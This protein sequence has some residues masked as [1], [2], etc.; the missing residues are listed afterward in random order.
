M[1]FKIKEKPEDF[2]VKEIIDIPLGDSGEYAYYKLRKVDRN[3][4]DIVR[5]LA[6]RF[7]LPVKNITFAGLKD[8]NAVTEQYLAIKGL[9]KIPKEVEGKNYKLSL[10]GFSDQPLELGNFKGNYFEIVVRNVSKGE[11]I[12]AERNLEF[13]QKYGF[14]NYFGEQRF[15][16]VK[17]A[18][19]FI[20]K[21]LLAH[22][23]EEALREYLLS[24]SD[25]RM[26]RRLK[27]LWG[28]WKEYLKAM[29][30]QAIYER[31]IVEELAKGVSYKQSFLALPKNIRLMFAFTYQSYLWNR[32]LYRFI[33]RYFSFCE[34]P[35]GI[36]DWTYAF[37]THMN[38]TIFEKVKNLE[39]PYL[40][41]EYKPSDPKVAKIIEE[42]LSEEG[43]SE[44]TLNQE[45]IGIKLFTDGVRK[46]IAIPKDLKMERVSRSAVKVSFTLP[47]GSYATVL[48]R[49]LFLCQHIQ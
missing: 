22:K 19:E 26:K 5:E 15:G 1:M 11:R 30:K 47:P 6:K 9:K 23:Y 48:L 28:N 18:K 12:N 40:G 49:K 34:V 37:Y 4:I 20:V 41:K 21:H 7:S 43:I 17:N 25:W 44:E 45:R 16:S 38:D 32:F 8:K 33:V 35:Q 13:I 39:I 36:K 46:A 14:A 2:F 10:V 42:I 27:K 24:Y 29:P 3:T 31:K